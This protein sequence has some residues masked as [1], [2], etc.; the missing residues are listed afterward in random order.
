MRHLPVF[1]CLASGY[2]DFW[3]FKLKLGHAG[4]AYSLFLSC[5]TS[6]P[7]L[8]YVFCVFKSGAGARTTQWLLFLYTWWAQLLRLVNNRG[9]SFDKVVD[10]NFPSLS[11]LPSI[12]TATNYPL[13]NFRLFFTFSYFSIFTFYKKFLPIFYFFLYFSLGKL[14]F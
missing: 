5:H 3:L 1:W 6:T 13:K 9:G 4:Y 11:L 14:H 8:I 7:I 2:L 10:Q 12:F